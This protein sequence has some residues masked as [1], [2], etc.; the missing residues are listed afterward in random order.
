MFLLYLNKTRLTS[1]ASSKSADQSDY[2]FKTDGQ[3][4]CERRMEVFVKNQ[5]KKF[6]G[7]GGG[8]GGG[9]GWM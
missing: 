6:G 8:G 4:G 3:G 1:Y 9:S 5:K 7:G 2:W